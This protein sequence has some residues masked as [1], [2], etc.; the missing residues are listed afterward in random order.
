MKKPIDFDGMFEEKLTVYMKANAGKYSEEEW[1]ERIPKLYS[2]FADTFVAAAGDTPRG[3]YEKMTDEELVSSLEAHER[4]GVPVNDFLLRAL[5]ERKP[6]ELFRLFASENEA[7]L[8]FAVRLGEGYEKKAV[9]PYYVHL[10]RSNP[11]EA[12]LSAATEYLSGAADE[13][14]E[15]LLAAIAEGNAREEFYEILSC[16]KERDERV[17]SLLLAAFET[18]QERLKRAKYLL[19]YGDE[20]AVKSLMKALYSAETDYIEYREL[21]NAVE[22]LGGVVEKERD[23]SADPAFL[24]LRY[25]SERAGEENKS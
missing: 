21:K 18:G 8:S 9:V 5:E 6:K 10:L 16:C 19:H 1:E 2:R 24:E 4:E 11:S 22:A 20:R 14:K 15:L 17:F 7:L 23:F 25:K 12:L 3:Y 13:S